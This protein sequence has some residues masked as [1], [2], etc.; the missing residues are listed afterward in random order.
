MSTKTKRLPAKASAA[1]KPKKPERKAGRVVAVRMYSPDHCTRR[2][3][4]AGGIV[5]AQ[6]PNCLKP[7]PVFVLPADAASVERMVEDGA[8][9]MGEYLGGWS[10]ISKHDKD[11]NRS[12]VRAALAAIGIRAQ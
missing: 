8:R 3:E 4:L 6:K 7:D 1:K 10:D 9:A 2:I 12:C 5:L 11:F